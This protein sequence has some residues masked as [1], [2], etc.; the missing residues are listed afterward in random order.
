M[1]DINNINTIEEKT[2]YLFNRNY[3]SDAE[4]SDEISEAC[5]E[6]ADKMISEYGWNKVFD[7]WYSY[8]TANCR[9]AESVC[10]FANL[11]WCYGGAE[12]PI[13]NAYDFLGYFYY[14]LELNPAKY[15]DDYGALTIM[16]GISNDIQEHSGLKKDIWLDD[17][18]VPEKD[19]EIIKSVEFWRSERGVVDVS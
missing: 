10:N 13:K 2:N 1:I 14:Y 3:S 7:S 19:P 12:H 9:S 16:D 17:D 15:E 18:Y 11:F 6:L 8:L 4:F 5:E